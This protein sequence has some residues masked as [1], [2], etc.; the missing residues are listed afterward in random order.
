MHAK[1]IKLGNCADKILDLQL[2]LENG[3]ITQAQFDIKVAIVRRLCLGLFEA[4]GAASTVM[5]NAI[6]NSCSPV[7]NLILSPYDPLQ[8]VVLGDTDISDGF[9]GFLGEIGSIGDLVRYTCLTGEIFMDTA[10]FYNIPR[11]V[12]LLDAA[13]LNLGDIPLNAMCGSLA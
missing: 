9:P 4:I 2:A 7:R 1:V 3:L 5:A 11:L 12:P 10:L 8:F 6:V 13:G